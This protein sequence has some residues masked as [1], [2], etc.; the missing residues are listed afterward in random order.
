[1]FGCFDVPEVVVAALK[2]R[3][4]P[5]VLMRYGHDVLRCAIKELD[6]ALKLEN[7]TDSNTIFHEAWKEFIRFQHIYHA[8][9]EGTNGKAEGFFKML[10]R[11]G[12]NAATKGGL[13]DD[14]TALDGIE[15]SVGR[16]Q[17]WRNYRGIRKTFPR[18]REVNEARYLK[19]EGIVQPA[20]KKV[21][22]EGTTDMRELAIQSILPTIPRSDLK[23]FISF[24]IEMLEKYYPDEPRARK[25]A[26]ALQVTATSADDWVAKKVILETAFTP[27]VYLH[28]RILIGC[29]AFSFRAH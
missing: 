27:K 22:A 2:P 12:D 5:F 8:I 7:G 1:M 9:E 26:H 21:V 4:D 28:Q 20:L 19:V 6:D 10:D 29:S 13:P 14:Q 3:D 18:F 15:H 25:F 11:L 23:F 24:G 16:A 17:W